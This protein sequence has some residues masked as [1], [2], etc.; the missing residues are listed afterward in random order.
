MFVLSRWS[1]G[2]V[3]RFGSKLPL[4]VGPLIASVGFALFA[5]P[6]VGAKYWTSFLPA[7]V[8]LGFGMAVSVAPLTTTVMGAVSEQQAGVASGINNA[9][10]RTAGLLAIAVFGVVMQQTFSRSLSEQLNAMPLDD[11]TRGSIYEQ[12]VK[13]AGIEVPS[14]VGVDVRQAVGTSFVHGFRLIM[15]T[16]AGLALASAFSSWLLIGKSGATKSS[17]HANEPDK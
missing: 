13:L 1:G 16:A 4:I 11:A 10:S 7:V 15:L 8:V 2:L 14:T 5:V 12:R 3:D 17:Q 9:V 6:G